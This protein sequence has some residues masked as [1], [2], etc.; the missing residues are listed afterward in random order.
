MNPIV[1]FI[2]KALVHSLE[3]NFFLVRYYA[4]TNHTKL[5]AL[6]FFP[7]VQKVSFVNYAKTFSVVMDGG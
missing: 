6:E 5:H 2:L 7:N 4:V 1:P 3:F